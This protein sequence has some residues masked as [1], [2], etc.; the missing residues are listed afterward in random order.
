VAVTV[1]D[2]GAGMAPEVICRAT[3]PFFTTKKR[4]HG[5]GLGLSMVQ[6]FAEQSGG[7]LEIESAPSQGT[8]VTIVL[9]RCRKT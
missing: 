5:T 8:R 2:I 9:P 3:E 1:S 7:R 6:G 4:G